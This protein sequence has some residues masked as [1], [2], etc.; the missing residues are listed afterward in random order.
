[1]LS[2][3]LWIWDGIRHQCPSPP[4]NE[5]SFHPV[6]LD[7]WKHFPA[8]YRS[9][10]QKLTQLPLSWCL[11]LRHFLVSR[12][13][14]HTSLM[15]AW[16]LG[17]WVRA[18]SVKCLLLYKASLLDCNCGISEGCRPKLWEP[19]PESF[20]PWPLAWWP[21]E[22]LFGISRW[23]G[24]GLSRYL[25]TVTVIYTSLHCRRPPNLS[26]RTGLPVFK[27]RIFSM[28]YWKHSMEIEETH[29]LS[30]MHDE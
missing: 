21:S 11:H 15:E 18:C 20:R 24:K 8:L 22:E 27:A 26:N 14:R 17:E 7:G 28:G 5:S 10:P 19:T 25:L 12:S 9:H 16:S 23:P 13:F 1:M 29:S 6:L 4:Q 3:K 30:T 2:G